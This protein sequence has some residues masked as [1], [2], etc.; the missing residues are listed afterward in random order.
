M[1]YSRGASLGV[2]GERV[3]NLAGGASGAVRKCTTRRN[4]RVSNSLVLVVK[5]SYGEK[6]HCQQHSQGAGEADLHCRDA[7]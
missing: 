6:S 3:T 5:N 7:A 2:S 4:G 1:R